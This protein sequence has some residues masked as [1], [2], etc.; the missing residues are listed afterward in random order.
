M[1]FGSRGRG[2]EAR[3]IAHYNT[4]FQIRNNTKCGCGFLAERILP[5][6]C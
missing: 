1:E 4:I 3:R 2:L 6:S 5:H